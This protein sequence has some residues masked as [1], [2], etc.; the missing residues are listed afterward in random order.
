MTRPSAERRL[1][2]HAVTAA[3][4]STCSRLA[5]GAVLATRAGHILSTGYNGAPAGRPHC[6]HRDDRPCRRAQHAERNAIA[7]AARYQGGAAGAVLYLTHAP[8]LDCAGMV[9]NSGI[10]EVIY[11]HRYRSDE[12]I[13]ELRAAGVAVHQHT[14]EED[15]C[16]T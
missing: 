7:F 6:V 9:I 3:T 16:L 5:V 8:C 2:D 13:T 12:G 10:A 1:L 15:G 4:G 14:R 11:L